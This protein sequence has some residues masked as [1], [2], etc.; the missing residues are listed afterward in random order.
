MTVA[1]PL[2]AADG[3]SGPCAGMG[4]FYPVPAGQGGYLRHS[5]RDSHGRRPL[6]C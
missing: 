2:G 6:L 3:E 5:D 1:E 4:E